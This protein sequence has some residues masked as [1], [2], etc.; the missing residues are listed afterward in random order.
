MEFNLT[1]KHFAE[2]VQKAWDDAGFKNALVANP[3]KTIEDYT[4]VKMN[5]PS[6]LSFV[7][8]DQSDESKI[9]FNIPRKQ[10]ES[11]IELTDEQ[12][13]MV[14]GGD[15]VIVPAAVGCGIATVALCVA[16]YAMFT[17]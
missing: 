17:R 5:L 12:L 6:G 3:E 9:Y 1:E 14:A 8:V 11:S 10:D 16:A 2:I 7:A 4:G 15:F 13:E